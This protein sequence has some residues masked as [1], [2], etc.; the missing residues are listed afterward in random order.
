MWNAGL[1]MEWLGDGRCAWCEMGWN[2]TRWLREEHWCCLLDGVGYWVV[3][4]GA[5]W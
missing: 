5:W 2:G 3:S 1:R 4:C